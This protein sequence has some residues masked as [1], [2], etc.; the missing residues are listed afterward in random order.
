MSIKE[1]V[2][3]FNEKFLQISIAE[4]KTIYR[5]TLVLYLEGILDTENSG[6]FASVINECIANNLYG[7]YSKLVLD[8]NGITY[9]S[10]TGIGGFVNILVTCTHNDITLCLSRVPSRISDIMDLLGFSSYFTFID[11]PNNP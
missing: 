3:S 1:V 8:C 4:S 6:D 5:D 11:D 9:V 2:E 10:S 7:K